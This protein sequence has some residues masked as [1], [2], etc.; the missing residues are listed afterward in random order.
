MSGSDRIM[1]AAGGGALVLVAA[2][3]WLLLVPSIGAPPLDGSGTLFVSS[4]GAPTP[5]PSADGATGIIV[6]DVQGGV[7]EPGVRELPP[8]ARVADAIEAA[9]GYAADA[10]LVAA[11]AINLAEPLADGAQVRVPRIG[12]AVA[13]VRTDAAAGSG[14]SGGATG[15]INLNTAT[16][17]ELEALPGVGPVTVQKIVAARAEQPFASLDDAVARGVINRGQLEDIQGLATAG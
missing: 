12:D 16:P 6:V 10:D 4:S 2:A 13:A 11:A 7:A 14:G 9:G 15:P 5:G 17:E 3:A 1:L 8:G